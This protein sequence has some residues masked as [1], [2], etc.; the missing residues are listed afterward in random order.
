MGCLKIAYRTENEPSLRCIW[1][2]SNRSKMGVNW[3]DYGARFYDP[4]LG[5]WHVQDPLAEEHFETT[6]YHYCFNN[7]LLF[8]DPAGLDTV[9]AN[10]NKT[11][12]KDDVVVMD[13]GSTA[14]ASADDV[15]ITPGT[16]S[17]DEQES[18]N[19]ET[20]ETNEANI[21][22]TISWQPIEIPLPAFLVKGLT[23]VK[24]FGL[25]G[26]FLFLQGDTRTTYQPPPKELP[27]F[28]GA[29]RVK[30]RAGRARWKLP[31]G[32]IAEWDSQHGEVEVYDKTGKKHK[33]AYDPKSGKK[34]KPRKK[35]RKTKK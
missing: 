27:G 20:N 25:I 7:P 2:S 12:N 10:T 17:G 26:S 1:K 19:T 9:N 16:D 6:P 15:V 28:P 11:V 18:E 31:N 24:A 30:P 35:G 34:V 13:D 23:R 33:G 32:D 4:S 29:T 5:R 22:P 3:Y 21:A 14:N 8:I